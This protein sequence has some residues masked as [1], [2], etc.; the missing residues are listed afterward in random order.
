MIVSMDFM[1]TH[2]DGVLVLVTGKQKKVCYSL[3]MH[4]CVPC[5]CMCVHDAY[6]CTWLVCIATFSVSSQNEEVSPSFRVFFRTFYIKKMEE[7]MFIMNDNL[8]LRWD[9]KLD[10]YLWIAALLISKNVTNIMG[11]WNIFKSVDLNLRDLHI[12][13]LVD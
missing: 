9:E 12:Y 6:V 1:E 11:C 5:A 8:R 7:H 3:C 4:M 13:M 10:E 2:D